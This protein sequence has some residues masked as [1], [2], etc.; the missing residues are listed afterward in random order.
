MDYH[1]FFQIFKF[2]LKES[3]LMIKIEVLEE[4]LNY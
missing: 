2:E 1:I 4:K 3:I